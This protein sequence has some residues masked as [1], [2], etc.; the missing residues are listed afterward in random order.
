V[1]RHLGKY[2][3]L[4]ETLYYRIYSPSNENLGVTGDSDVD[5]LIEA[6][7]KVRADGEVKL[8]AAEGHGP[9]AALD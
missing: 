5:G 3:P 8:C 2:Q 6:S 4:F 7:F 1:R 9:G